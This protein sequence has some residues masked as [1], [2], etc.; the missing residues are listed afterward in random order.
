[1]VYPRL[2]HWVKRFRTELI[3]RGDGLSCKIPYA[4]LTRP[5]GLSV[6]VDRTGATL[7]D[8]AAVL[9]ACEAELVTQRPKQRHLRNN[10]DFVDYTVD[11]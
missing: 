6:N 11:E 8:T 9:D 4:R 10:M 3:N 5:N 2:L 7:S 1:M